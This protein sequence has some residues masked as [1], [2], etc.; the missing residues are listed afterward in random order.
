MVVL[1]WLQRRLHA[2]TMSGVV[3]GL[4]GS[5]HIKLSKRQGRHER[6]G[7]P[8]ES[9]SRCLK[10]LCTPVP[11]HHPGITALQHGVLPQTRS[12]HGPPPTCQNDGA[13]NSG[14]C[15]SF[16]P[17]P[18]L[19]SI[20]LRLEKHPARAIVPCVHS[21]LAVHKDLDSSMLLLDERQMHLYS[22]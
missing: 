8:R 1:Q 22:R 12:M 13:P 20:H 21:E 4:L 9:T 17:S 10:F 2:K 19:P 14:F 18:L 6:Q 5:C 7:R 11:A 15:G 3:S 16:A